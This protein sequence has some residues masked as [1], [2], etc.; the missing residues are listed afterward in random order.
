MPTE[1]AE[2]QALGFEVRVRPVCR[3]RKYSSQQSGK[4]IREYDAFTMEAV[5]ATEDQP[6]TLP[7]HEVYTAWLAQQMEQIANLTLHQDQTA[8]ICYQSTR[9]FRKRNTRPVSGPDAVLRG[10][11]SIGNPEEIPRIL[12]RGIGRHRAYGYGMLLL[13]P[14][15]S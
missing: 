6:N 4:T 14:P 15:G 8:L 13:K 11:L 9:S 1:W 7:R 3:T 12:D 10:T 2:G 5:S